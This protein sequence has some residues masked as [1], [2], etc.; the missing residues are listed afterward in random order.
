LRFCLIDD[1]YETIQLV[2][3]AKL[4]FPSPEWDTISLEAKDF[5]RSLL[6]REAF[7]RPTAAEA[8][9]HPWIAKHVVEPG[10]P[11]PRP[12]RWSSS[13]EE[14]RATS[15]SIELRMDSTRRTAF[16]KFL[17][18]LKIK[19]AMTG[20]AQLLT[21][22]EAQHL[23]EVFRKVDKDQDGI[24]SLVDLDLAVQNPSFS[25]SVRQNLKIMRARLVTYPKVNFDIRPFIGLVNKRAHS[26]STAD[27]RVLHPSNKI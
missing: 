7:M 23:G 20:A 9:K 6:E 19:K 1:D 18:G 3:N 17:A 8:L 12:F 15:E 26:D 11:P 14:L 21:P 4:D 2:T 24:I 27:E 25:T 10:I 13:S 22:K 5:V 16:Q